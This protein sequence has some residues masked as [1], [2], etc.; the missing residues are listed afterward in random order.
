MI[1]RTRIVQNPFG[2]DGS[3]YEAFKPATFVPFRAIRFAG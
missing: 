3:R 1:S 2:L